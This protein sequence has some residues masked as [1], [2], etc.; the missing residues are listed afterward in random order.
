MLDDVIRFSLTDIFS[1]F[2]YNSFKAYT[3]KLTR[4]AE[5]DLDDDVLDSFIRK[6][7]KSLS[8]RKVGK[9]VRFIYDHKIPEDLLNFLIKNLHPGGV[10]GDLISGARYHNFK[11]FMNFPKIDP[12]KFLYKSTP[13]LPHPNIDH[14][15][16]LLKTIQKKD[17]LLH[18]PY[19]TF[20]YI[21]DFLREAAIDPT[22][23]SIRITLYRVAKKS[24]IINALVN[25]ARNGKK[26]IVV[27][28]LQARF[29]EEANIYWSRRLQEDGVKVIHSAP[30]FKVH[31]KL[32]LI[33]RKV[34]K[35]TTLFANVGTGNFH[36]GTAKLY[37][38]HALLTCD[39]R[40]TKE[41]QK[42]FD[43]LENNFTR[44][45]FRHL[46]V[47]PF[48]MRQKLSK[49]IDTEIKNA[50]K[51]KEAYIIAKLN[52]LT[53]TKIIK[54]LYRASQA[55]VSV[56]L[57]VRGMFSLVTEI[58]GVS[59]NIEATGTIDK[60]LEH[61]R[62]YVFCHGG[63]EKFYLT[64]ADWMPRNLDRRVEVS[65][66]IYDKDIRK[67]ILDYINIHLQDNV[68]ARVLN[69]KLDNIYNVTNSDHKNQ[70]QFELY[71]YFKQKLQQQKIEETIV[72]EE[73]EQQVKS[74]DFS[75][76]DASPQNI[77][78]TNNSSDNNKPKH[79]P[80][81]VVEVQT[82]PEE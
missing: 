27:L 77:P 3:I 61:T 33:K 50:A 43:F 16:S 52:N 48:N 40:I 76:S 51:G 24:R 10:K 29:D 80:E 67:E 36:E 63:N 8:Q 49:L 25:A 42:V 70:A 18:Y 12:D 20:D 39:P 62:I 82:E 1:I 23:V 68:K 6:I 75:V 74:T 65:C 71:Q 21:I 38:D 73:P 47:S 54:K 14:H 32:I 2:D 72:I 45:T 7:S 41:V 37:T 81:T 79:T 19:Q 26:V 30:N 64:S 66:P 13:P 53:D 28:E 44:Q 60:F 4:D 56:K 22:V 17:I 78:E 15:Q 57:L 5:L 46:L 59:E 11:D 31:S 35:K 55:G 9:P 69:Q 58:Q 34:E